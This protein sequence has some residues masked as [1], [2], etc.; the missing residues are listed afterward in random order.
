MVFL[1]TG[2]LLA[3]K[4]SI[5][6]FVVPSKPDC[7]PPPTNFAQLDYLEDKTWLQLRDASGAR[8]SGER[9]IKLV[10]CTRVE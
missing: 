3:L 7:Y 9:A 2:N 6:G 8:Q 5:C 1:N 10:T 4:S